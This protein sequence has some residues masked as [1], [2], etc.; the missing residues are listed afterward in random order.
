[1]REFADEFR[2]VF[3]LAFE[4]ELLLFRPRMLD[5]FWV[6]EDTTLDGRFLLRSVLGALSG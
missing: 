3:R 4:D 5:D 6:V 2:E 1:M